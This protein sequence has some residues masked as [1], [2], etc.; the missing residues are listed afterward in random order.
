MTTGG[1]LYRYAT[2]DQIQLAGKFNQIPAF[3]FLGKEETISDLVGEKLSEVYL[4]AV[5][6]SEFQK[7]K[8]FQNFTM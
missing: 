3:R 7:R 6:K 1:G 8:L 4:N 2:K 5:L